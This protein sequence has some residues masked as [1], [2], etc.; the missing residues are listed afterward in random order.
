MTHG[1]TRVPPKGACIYCGKTGCKLT[2][3]HI[4]PY[5]IGG[6]HVIDEAS[7][8]RCARITS[9]FELDV[10]RD[11][12][13]DARV[14]FGA[15]SRRKNKRPKYFSHPNKFAPHYP[16]KVPFSD[17]PAAMIFYKMQPAGILV[18]LPSSVNQ[19]GRWELISIADKAKLNQFKL[20]YGVDPI[21]RFKHVPDSF[22]RLLI[23]IAYG[24]VLCSLDPA[25]F[26]AICLP[27]ILEEGRN[28]SYIVGGRW[29]LP[30]PLSRELVIRSIQIA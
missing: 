1:H 17:Y 3:E 29:D 11:L 25:D 12:W 18:G 20:E 22:A 13:G 15:P 6:Q 4:L 7:C 8:D 5:F 26:N 30:P 23:K 28:Y 27:Y 2:D 9:K 10:G 14:S 19:A 16:I 24:Q 21:A